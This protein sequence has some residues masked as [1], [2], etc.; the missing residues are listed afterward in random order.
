MW[1]DS[2]ALRHPEHF[3]ERLNRRLEGSLPGREAQKQL[4]PHPRHLTPPPDKV[5]RQSAVL[6]PLLAYREEVHLLLTVRTTTLNHHGGEVSFPGGAMELGDADLFQTALREAQEEIGLEP[7]AVTLLGQL[8]DLY[9]P[10]SNNL[11][12]PFVGWLADV[13]LLQA[14]P[15]EVERIFCVPL[16]FLLNIENRQQ[17]QWKLHGQTLSVPFYRVNGDKIWGATAM[18]LG[19]LLVLVEET[20][21]GS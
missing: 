1:N 20:T 10:P 21:G 3:K 6:I 12:H 15:L 17:E 11:V 16:R 19:E 18:M 7:D 2:L 4:A 13:A 8:T 14:N 5:P 9:I